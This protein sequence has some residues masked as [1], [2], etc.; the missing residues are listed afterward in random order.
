M[1]VVIDGRVF[2][3][4]TRECAMITHRKK[5]RRQPHLRTLLADEA[6]QKIIASSEYSLEGY[7]LM[8]AETARRVDEKEEKLQKEGVCV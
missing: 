6:M 4:T 2:P 7:R 1:L 8:L 3:P 5:R